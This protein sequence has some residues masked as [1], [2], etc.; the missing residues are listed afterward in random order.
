[1]IRPAP[2]DPPEINNKLWEGAE[3]E[4]GWDIGANCGQSCQHMTSA[5]Q[6]VYAFEPNP[7][8]RRILVACEFDNV[9]VCDFAISDHNGKVILAAIPDLMQTGQYAT[10]GTHGMEWDQG[11]MWEKIPH[12]EV[13]CRTIDSLAYDL[14]V[15]D[16]IKVDTE[17]HEGFILL[18]AEHTLDLGRTSWLIEFHS[19]ELRLSCADLLVSANYYVE[20]IRHPHYPYN[21]HMWHQHGWLKAAAPRR[22]ALK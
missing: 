20:T 12:T 11:N 9:T 21:S 18:G 17:G 10:P 13:P 3:G 4:I 16:F 19:P 14:S 8:A 22:E 7:D 6:N 1:M 15:P 5:F 2:T